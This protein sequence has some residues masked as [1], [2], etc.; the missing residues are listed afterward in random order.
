MTMA[1]REELQAKVDAIRLKRA[2][3]KEAGDE[4]IA[5][6]MLEEEIKLDELVAEYGELGR[7]VAAVFSPITGDMVAVRTPS[8]AAFRLYQN[9]ANTGKL[10]MDQIM[11]TL[12]NTCRIYPDAEAFGRVQ[13]ST[14]S[15]L[16]KAANAAARL[17]GVTQDDTEGK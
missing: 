7:K 11:S 17:A 10:S 6:R 5:I 15:M 12:L 13:D 4:A 16:G 3:E 2:A 8:K 14:P 9:S 1:T